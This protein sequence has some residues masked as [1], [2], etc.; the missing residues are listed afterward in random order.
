VVRAL[1]YL[2]HLLSGAA[3][4]LIW[5]WLLNP[6][7]GW[8]NQALRAVYAALDPLVRVLSARGTTGWGMPDW[9]YSP[10]WCMPALVLVHVWSFGATM[11]IFL[12]ALR[13]VDP[14]LHEAARL[15]G[16][17]KWHRLVNVTLPQI[18]PVIMF[19]AVV[20][21]VLSLQ[22]FTEPF[23]LTQRGQRDG[24]LLFVPYLYETAFGMTPRLG[25]ASAV[26]VI[27]VGVTLLAV[28]PMVFA[29]RRWSRFSIRGSH[30]P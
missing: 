4:V 26:S 20:L 17:T 11:L 1:A 23:L 3:T 2:P 19:N 30:A 28:L 27:F 22:A 25:Y 14:S 5:G 12:A 29:A 18:A 8:I 6:R 7:F 21:T 16:A 10:T 9:L 15:D 24:L 13:R